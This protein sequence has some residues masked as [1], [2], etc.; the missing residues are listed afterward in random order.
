MKNG[1][2]TLV[3]API[4]YP[5]KKY[6]GKYCYEHHLVW[7]S[8]NGVIPS[9]AQVVHHINEDKRDNRVEN[10]ELID[11]DQHT[12]R[13]SVPAEVKTKVCPTCDKVFPRPKSYFDFKESTGQKS[14]FCS[15][16]CADKSSAYA[17]KHR[18]IEIPHGG[19]TGYSYHKC[20]CALCK[21]AHRRRHRQYRERKRKNP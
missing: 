6:R 11:R 13:H 2:Y 19:S 4:D 1:D 20:R 21:E 10:L 17:S 9:S 5:G 7:W 16:P 15:K 12:R 8:E 3:K 14:F 18:N